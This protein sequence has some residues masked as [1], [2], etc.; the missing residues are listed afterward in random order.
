MQRY[1]FEGLAQLFN[2]LLPVINRKF[3]DRRIRIL[4]FTCSGIIIFNGT[5]YYCFNFNFHCWF[6]VWSLLWTKHK[7]LPPRKVSTPPTASQPVSLYEDVNTLP[8]S[9]EEHHE[10]DF[11]LK[12]NVAYGPSKTMSVK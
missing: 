3:E 6:C 9:A 12:E 8:T 1:L 7:G 4:R 10:K 5:T 2:I 11:E